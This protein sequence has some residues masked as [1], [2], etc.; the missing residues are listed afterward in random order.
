MR[1]PASDDVVARATSDAAGTFV[2]EIAATG[3]YRISVERQGFYAI[4][5][6]LDDAGAGQPTCC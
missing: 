4:E 6:Q 5:H 2:L 1:T 3:A